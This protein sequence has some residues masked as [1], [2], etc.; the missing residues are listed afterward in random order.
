MLSHEI[1][2]L[3]PEA[4]DLVGN[5]AVAV[6]ST[7]MPKL[8]APDRE[9]VEV[10]L[11]HRRLASRTERITKF[12]ATPVCGERQTASAGLESVLAPERGPVPQSN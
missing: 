7:V 1:H 10:T 4:T 12:N 6:T 11:G 5:G 9:P 8:C 3:R 2:Q